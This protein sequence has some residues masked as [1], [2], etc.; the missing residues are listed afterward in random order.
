MK[1]K[2]ARLLASVLAT[3]TVMSG[4]TPCVAYAQTPD[5]VIEAESEAEPEIAITPVEEELDYTDYTDNEPDSEPAI[6]GVPVGEEP[7]TAEFT[8]DEPDSEPAIVGVPVGEEPETAEYT[9]NEPDS[10]PAIVGV[11]VGEEPETIEFTDNKPDLEPAVAPAPVEETAPAAEIIVPVHEYSDEVV[12]TDIKTIQLTESKAKRIITEY[13]AEGWRIITTQYLQ[14]GEVVSQSVYNQVDE[15]L[16]MQEESEQVVQEME[17]RAQAYREEE[18]RKAQAIRDEE[19]AEQVITDTLNSLNPDEL[20]EVYSAMSEGNDTA[21]IRQLVTEVNEA[22]SDDYGITEADARKIVTSLFKNLVSGTFKALPGA[23]YY[24][25]AVKGI[26][27]GALGL[28][29]EKTDIQAVVNKGTDKISKE[30][31][32]GFAQTQRNIDNYGTL[33]D[34]GERL[35]DFTDY[36]AL[37]SDGIKEYEKNY[38]DLEKK[39]RIANLIGSSDEWYTGANNG[40]IMKALKSA[41]EVFKG[42]TNVDN[43]DLFNIVYDINKESSLFSGEAMAKSQGKL[44]KAVNGFINNCKIVLKCLKAHEEIADFTDEQ[45]ASL[46]PQTRAIYDRIHANK[47]TIAS[48]QRE[49]A[50]IFIG[51]KSAE[52]EKDRYGIMDKAGQYYAKSKTTYVNYGSNGEGIALKDTLNITN[53]RD[54]IKED[55][56][57]DLNKIDNAVKASGLTA[58]DIEKIAYHAKLHGMTITEYLEAVGFNTENLK[59]Y[60]YLLSNA[61]YFDEE[62]ALGLWKLGPDKEGAQIYDMNNKNVTVGKEDCPLTTIGVCL[63]FGY[64]VKEEIYGNSN[65]NVAFVTFE[66]E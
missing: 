65:Q 51:D 25:D 39:V 57:T 56:Y 52:E 27:F 5:E 37:R 8:D 41:S 46:D 54:Y 61:Y 43:R 23:N 50:A 60:K 2:I 31:T 29:D 6:V 45:I 35:D 28:E 62:T 22:T 63:E 16:E 59:G 33:K 49:V 21:F 10:E 48:K 36:A 1:A 7:E 24:G 66:K 3:V 20:L 11:P 12:K 9:D 55:Q 58:E 17:A 13:T 19:T 4:M 53:G 34:Y 18:A 44:E 14:D 32:E 64:K 30:L 47:S 15:R 40:N 42:Q 38:S 26:I